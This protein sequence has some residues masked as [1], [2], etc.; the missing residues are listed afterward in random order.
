MRHYLVP[1]LAILAACGGQTLP[2]LPPEAAIVQ[3]NLRALAALP[4]DPQMASPQQIRELVAR[5]RACH[6][7]ADGGAP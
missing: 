7:P 3:C 2:P 4:D 5:L 6:A 1:A